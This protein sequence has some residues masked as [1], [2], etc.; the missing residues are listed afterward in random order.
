MPFVFPS[1]AGRALAVAALACCSAAT[2]TAWAADPVPVE[3]FFKPAAMRGPVLS[4]SGR[5]LGVLTSV[6]KS[7]VG[8]SMIDLEGGEPTR[9]IEAS[10]QADVDW[11]QWV[12]EDWLVFTVEDPDQRSNQWRGRGL[13]TVKRD[14]SE[15]RMLIQRQWED[16]DPFRRRKTL[17]PTYSYVGVGA[18][19]STDVVVEELKFD[20]RWQYSHSTPMLLNVV[21][22][23]VRSLAPDAP[24]S[25]DVVLDAQGRARV[26][27]DSREGTTTVHW[28]ANGAAPWREIAR[29]PSLQ[30]TFF[31]LYVD[32]DDGLVVAVEAPGRGELRRFDF[33]NGKPSGEAMLAVP[34]FSMNAA[35]VQLRGSN[36]VLG[37]ALD[38]DAVST[39]WFDPDMQRLQDKV[40]AKLPGRVNIIT[41]RPCSKPKVVLVHSYS[42][43]VPGEF[44]LYRPEQDRWQLLGEARPDIDARRMAGLEF[45]RAKARDGRDLPVWVTRPP[46]AGNKPAPAVVLVHGG[47]WVKGNSWRWDAHAQFLA[48][49][50]YVVIEPEFRGSSGY[51]FAHFRA[52]WKQWGLTMQDDVSDAL[53]FA[54]AQG[55]VDPKR[56][57]IVGGSYGG[58]AALMGLVKDPA[59]YRCGVAFAAVSDPRHMFNMHWSDISDEGRRF[60]LRQLIGDPQG[61]AAQMIATSPVEQAAKITA[62]VLLLHGGKDRR[63]PIEN[64]EKMRDALQKAGKQV[65]WVTYPDEGH[66]FARWENEVDYWKRVEAFLGQHLK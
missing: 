66:G 36:R 54:A 33:A 12:N 6:G 39:Q 29:M 21:T 60:G 19:G 57:C 7:R 35:P 38:T 56:A 44:V 1:F 58:Y 48:S 65:Q 24:K 32:G 30:T 45:H 14:G 18:P 46:G 64:G 28:S 42:D 41:C 61:D 4:P 50:G 40:D 16:E 15:S 47:P 27:V 59:Q 49:R 37:V 22:G 63:V 17:P 26:L 5:W 43:T 13:M 23:G 10:T 25:Q 62:P 34:G 51:G 11:I 3:A 20:T 55:W 8:I 31:P 53:K 9:F 2:P 52:G